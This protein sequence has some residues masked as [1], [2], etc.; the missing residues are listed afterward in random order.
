MLKNLFLTLSLITA[1]AASKIPESESSED[2]TIVF[3]EENVMSHFLNLKT[4]TQSFNLLQA[5]FEVVKYNSL[6]LT[7]S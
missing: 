4:K 6:H 7:P 2:E 5:S 1:I 3:N